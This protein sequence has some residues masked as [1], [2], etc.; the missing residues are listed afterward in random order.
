MI[1]ALTPDIISYDY[2][3]RTL[4]KDITYG[5]WAGTEIKATKTIWDKLKLTA[6]MEYTL[7]FQ[8]DSGNYDLDPYA[9]YLDDRR[10]SSIWGAYVQ[11]DY[12]LT[13]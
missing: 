7:N 8:Q 12:A 4:N 9:R 10:D 2:P 13:P 5:Q 1:T 3:P 6:G 11:G